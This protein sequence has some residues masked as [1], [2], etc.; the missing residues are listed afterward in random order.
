MLTPC[1]DLPVVDVCLCATKLIRLF[2]IPF[3]VLED[4]VADL[5]SRHL[6]LPVTTFTSD[7]IVLINTCHILFVT[8]L[9]TEITMDTVGHHNGVC[10]L[11][12]NDVNS[13][14]Y[15]FVPGCSKCST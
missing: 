5:D 3:Q 11:T 1:C 7:L 13:F 6:E 14:E 2:E 8:T 12:T 15:R 10:N 4:A 9:P